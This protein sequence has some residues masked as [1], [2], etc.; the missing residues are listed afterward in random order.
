MIL[1]K[2]KKYK[3]ISAL[4]IILLSFLAVLVTDASTR[5]ETE[6]SMNVLLTQSGFGEGSPFLKKEIYFEHLGE[7]RLGD[8]EIQSL[9]NIIVR[10]YEPASFIKILKGKLN[11]NYKSNYASKLNQW[12]QSPLGKKILAEE[13]QSRQEI[14]LQEIQKFS[15][16]LKSK[17]SDKKRQKL[18]VRL[19]QLKKEQDV[20]EE[21]A[22]I[23]M[24]LTFPYRPLKQGR[25]LI[26]DRKKQVYEHILQTLS[27]RYRNLSTNE[28]QQ[29]VDFLNSSHQ[30]WF[31]KALQL[32]RLESLDFSVDKGI[33]LLN[34]VM[35]QIRSKRGESSLLKEIFPPGERYRMIVQRDP[36]IPLISGGTGSASKKDEIKLGR[37]KK[38]TSAE[39]NRRR[40]AQLRSR[41]P[42][43]PVEFLKLMKDSRPQLFS[44]LEDYTRT[45]SNR[46]QLLSMDDEVFNANFS[47]YKKLIRSVKQFRKTI[48]LTPLQTDYK[49][50]QLV[51]ILKKGSQKVAMIQTSK[52]GLTIKKGVLV[53]PNFGIVERIDDQKIVILEQARDYAG[54]IF[55]KKK[56]LKFSNNRKNTSEAPS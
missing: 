33:S 14:S 30:K 53:G 17:T 56:E 4:G 10:Y 36:F 49:K 25:A 26:K 51:G 23:L 37:K 12:Y 35:T 31:D 32:S 46:D 54:N 2:Q 19:E 16:S 43:I 38:P 47:G 3:S 6:S 44:K 15:Q 50:F 41:L 27:H 11:K 42:S 24:Q 39:K 45:F 1:A 13:I 21:N 52:L 20:A 28:L 40:L 48:A 18:I 29:Y 8:G 7:L 9:E 22:E 55:S 5:A 34:Q